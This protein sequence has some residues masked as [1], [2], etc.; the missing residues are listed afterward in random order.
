MEQV[1][2]E[3]VMS[4][5]RNQGDLYEAMC[6]EI[7]RLRNIV[8]NQK[9]QIRV[10]TQTMTEVGTTMVEARLRLSEQSAHIDDLNRALDE[11]DKKIKEL[12]KNLKQFKD[13]IM[14]SV[15]ESKVLAALRSAEMVSVSH[16]SMKPSEIR[17]ILGLKD[18]LSFQSNFHVV[19]NTVAHQPV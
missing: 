6:T 17:L 16:N 5:Y 14:M 18:G 11:K 8:S 15:E 4:M 19:R 7:A 12:E 1:S 13:C 2:H 10:C 9:E 3:F